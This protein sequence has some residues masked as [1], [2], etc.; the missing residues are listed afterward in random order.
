MHGL[1]TNIVMVSLLLQRLVERCNG[2]WTRGFTVRFARRAP[3][4]MALRRGL[5]SGST[6]T[7]AL[8]FD[9]GAG[10]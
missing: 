6:P 1:D 2:A 5:A 8:A 3:A 7:R 4:T 10:Y 9:P